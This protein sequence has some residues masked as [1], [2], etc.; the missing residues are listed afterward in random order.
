M[1]RVVRRFL[2]G[3]PV[4]TRR[5]PGRGRGGR[6]ERKKSVRQ[7]RRLVFFFLDNILAVVFMITEILHGM[8]Q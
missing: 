5:N 1:Y 7:Q 6:S 2:R 8:V 4:G 3:H